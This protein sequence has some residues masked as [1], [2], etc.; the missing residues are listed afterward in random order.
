[1]EP[2]EAPSTFLTPI[3]FVRRFGGKSG[4]AKQTQTGYQ[5]GDD[6]KI[7]NHMGGSL[8]LLVIIGEILIEK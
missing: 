3:S 6:H 1:M 7:N 2:T 4:Q 5:H 8:L